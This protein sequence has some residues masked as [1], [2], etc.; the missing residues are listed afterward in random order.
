MNYIT[1][2]EL[3]RYLNMNVTDDDELLND[4]IA[5]STRKIIDYCKRH[6]DIIKDTRYYDIPYNKRGIFFDYDLLVL[7]TLTNGDGTTIS[8]DDYFLDNVNFYPK[9]RVRL[10]PSSSVNW[11]TDD[12][13]DYE[14]VI[15][16]TGLWGYHENYDS[17]WLTSATIASDLSDSA[18][19]I[20]VSDVSEFEIGNLIRLGDSTDYEFCLITGIDTDSDKLTVNRAKNGTDASAFV[21]GKS[22]SIYQIMD[23]VKLASLKL[24]SLWYR[25]KDTDSDSAIEII[26][27]GYKLIPESMP[28][29]VIQLLPGARPL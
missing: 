5:V 25:Q 16:V 19:E 18:T 23:N 13:S 7:E 14:Q 3:K 4:L 17:A 11:K 8:S 2:S 27:R 10:R 21:T 6:F 29:Q 15:S 1:L 24:V 12:N 22:V 26:E 9:Y 20:T 28:K